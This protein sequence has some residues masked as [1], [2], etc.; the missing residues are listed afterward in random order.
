MK[1]LLIVFCLCYFKFGLEAVFG[2]G[3]SD[4]LYRLSVLRCATAG[5]SEAMWLLGVLGLFALSGGIPCA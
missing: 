4:W 2:L 5:T 1:C 3:Y